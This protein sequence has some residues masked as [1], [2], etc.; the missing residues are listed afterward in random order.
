MS[1][2]SIKNKYFL[3][4]VESAEQLRR[5]AKYDQRAALRSFLVSLDRENERLMSEERGF[6]PQ[7]KANRSQIAHEK[8]RLENI[9]VVGSSSGRETGSYKEGAPSEFSE[10]GWPTD[11]EKRESTE[12]NEVYRA[13][14]Q[15]AKDS[16]QMIK[17]E[18]VSE[19]GFS[20]DN[21]G[22]CYYNGKI[23]RN[24]SDIH[25][26][27]YTHLSKGRR[28]PHFEDF[29]RSMERVGFK[30]STTKMKTRKGGRPKLRRDTFIDIGT[31]R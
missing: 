2:S 5:L 20:F 23:I 9:G 12:Q 25:Y 13:R 6:T 3:L 31:L 10:E 21:D 15:A 7:I 14:E 19:S 18:G 26:L 29:R 24:V 16:I 22:N 11:G 1:A 17:Q 28:P 30:F 4:A 27:E 8:R